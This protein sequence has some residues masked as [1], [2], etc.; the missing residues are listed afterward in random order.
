ME[1]FQEIMANHSDQKLIEIMRGRDKYQPIAV[2]AAINEAI[3]RKLIDNEA[4]IETKYPVEQSSVPEGNAYGN[5]VYINQDQIDEARRQRASKDMLYGGLW[6][7]G[8][9]ILTA[10]NIGFIFW[11]AILF[12][13]IQ[14][15]RGLANSQ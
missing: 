11:G 10:A 2:N 3:Q 1:G 9:I 13:G 7:V 15:F 14:F 6:C 8:G 12:G 5:P 4:E